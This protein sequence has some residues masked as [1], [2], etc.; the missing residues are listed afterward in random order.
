M[1]VAKHGHE[2]P[3]AGKGGHLIKSSEVLAPQ[4]G[5]R[6][7]V[8]EDLAVRPCR[9]PGLPHVPHHEDGVQFAQGL[10]DLLTNPVASTSRSDAST[11]SR[12][13]LTR[14]KSL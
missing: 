8:P 1:G 10:I 12:M 13:S 9:F 3:A 14:L 4:D 6:T 11:R 5:R 7:K 2:Q